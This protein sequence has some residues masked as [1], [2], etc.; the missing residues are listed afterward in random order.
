MADSPASGTSRG[1]EE[2]VGWQRQITF[3]FGRTYGGETSPQLRNIEV[4]E[5]LVLRVKKHCWQSGSACVCLFC[6]TESKLA[7][8]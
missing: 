5:G 3:H 1:S 2:S 7:G 6:M 8:L 4:F